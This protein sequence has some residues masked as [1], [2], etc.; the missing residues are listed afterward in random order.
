MATCQSSTSRCAGAGRRRPLRRQVVNLPQ[1]GGLGGVVHK[2]SRQLRF[3]AVYLP[4]GIDLPLMEGED[5]RR[6]QLLTDEPAV[7]MKA[8]E[9]RSTLRGSG[10]T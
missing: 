2:D 4:N 5:F 8:E 6:T 9:W 7:Q 10:W 3:V 1:L